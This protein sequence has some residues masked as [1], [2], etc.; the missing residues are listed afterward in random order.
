MKVF[1]IRRLTHGKAG[2][3]FRVYLPTHEFGELRADAETID[4]KFSG[5]YRKITIAGI[6]V[7]DAMTE[8]AA[9]VEIMN[10]LVEEIVGQHRSAHA[11]SRY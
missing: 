4:P 2:Y 11:V 6:P 9:A 1:D 5:D 3:G 8:D 7:L 10:L